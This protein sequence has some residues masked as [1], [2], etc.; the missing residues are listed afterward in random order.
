MSSLPIAKT[1]ESTRQ[2]HRVTDFLD[3]WN[4]T[5]EVPFKDLR[6]GQI[7]ILKDSDDLIEDGNVI[8][9]ANADAY[10][11][12]DGTDAIQCTEIVTRERH[13]ATWRYVHH[14]TSTKPDITDFITR[15]RNLV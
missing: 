13:Y 12:P 1:K 11:L 9:V 3:P 10:V 15:E 7:F 5:V 4:A 8:N 14:Y 2:C 6:K